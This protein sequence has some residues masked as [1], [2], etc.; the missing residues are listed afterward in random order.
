MTI[1]LPL[2]T[3]QY[4]II[5]LCPGAGSWAPGTGTLQTVS[6]NLEKMQVLL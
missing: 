6:K 1:P 3:T 4:F 2:A 5:K